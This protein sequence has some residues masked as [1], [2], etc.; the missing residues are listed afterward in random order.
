MGSWSWCCR[1]RVQATGGLKQQQRLPHRLDVVYAN[2]LNSLGSQ[3]QGHANGAS[4][5][6][7]FLVCQHVCN[8]SLARMSDQQRTSDP[9]EV[10]AVGQQREIL[11]VCFSKADAGIKTNPVVVNPPVQQMIAALLES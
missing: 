9:V 6:V 2:Y 1:P 3:R 7:R 11:L 5:A 10:L 8:E 4:C